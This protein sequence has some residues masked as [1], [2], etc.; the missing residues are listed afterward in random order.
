MSVALSILLWI[1]AIALGLVAFVICMPLHLEAR[2]WIEDADGE[3]RV[4]ARWGWLLVRFRADT[5]AGI[6]LR[7]LGIRV[8]RLGGRK[9]PARKENSAKAEKRAAKIAATRAKARAKRR[10]RGGG[11]WRHRRAITRTLGAVWHAIPVR[12]HLY[13]AIGLSDPG[14]TAV[15]FAALEPLTGRTG[16]VDLDLEA[17]WVES[18][19][20]IDGAISVRVWPIHILLALLWLVVRDGQT[21]RGMWALLRARR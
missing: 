4:Q 11:I 21:R 13:G 1:L 19:L 14:D 18:T 17:D 9:R 10:A 16:E 12:G 3:G 5:G 6:D 15:L 2:G 20:A 8:W 7:V